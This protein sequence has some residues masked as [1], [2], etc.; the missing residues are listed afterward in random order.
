MLETNTH[1]QAKAVFTINKKFIITY[2]V[3]LVKRVEISEGELGSKALKTSLDILAESL[4][5]KII[6]K[7]VQPKT[8][9]VVSF[10]KDTGEFLPKYRFPATKLNQNKFKT[11][12]NNNKEHSKSII[13]SET[14]K[15][16]INESN[17]I[18]KE[19]EMFII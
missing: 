6:K 12:I 7:E 15:E 9:T 4:T 16:L 11:A 2:T 17:N 8:V 13:F 18:D 19:L 10:E 3:K 5:T 1:A 14:I